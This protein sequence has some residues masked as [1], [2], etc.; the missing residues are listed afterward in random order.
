MKT[1]EERFRDKYRVCDDTGCWLWT[2]YLNQNGYGVISHERK[3]ILA[4]RASYMIHVGDIPADDG[5]SKMCVL[6]HCDTPPC[7]NPDHLFTGTNQDNMDDCAAKGRLAKLSGENH[8]FAKL[9]DRNA[10][11]IFNLAHSGLMWGYEI[12]EMFGIH[13]TVVS[14]IKRKVA[15]GHIHS[16]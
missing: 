2:A 6:H 11:S 13:K 5:L 15:W 9:T 16:A 10:M 3:T 8:P 1:L 14:D 4:H 12:A 7:V